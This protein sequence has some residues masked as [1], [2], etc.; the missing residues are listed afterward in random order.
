MIGREKHREEV[1]RKPVPVP[2]RNISGL[3]RTSVNEV[4]GD[5]SGQQGDE[6]NDGEEQ[7]AEEKF[8]DARNYG[9]AEE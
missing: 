8:R 9:S 4:A 2:E 7:V 6:D 1:R 3:E 5:E